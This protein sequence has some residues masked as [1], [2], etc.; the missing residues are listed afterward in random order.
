M[1]K[2]IVWEVS[3]SN[4][5]LDPVPWLGLRLPLSF[6]SVDRCDQLTLMG[7]QSFEHYWAQQPIHN[8][9]M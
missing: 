8:N 2:D 4:L 1:A 7:R 5:F 3:D 9:T 6:Q